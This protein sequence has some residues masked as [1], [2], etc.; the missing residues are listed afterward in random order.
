MMYRGKLLV[1]VAI[2]LEDGS[3]LQTPEHTFDTTSI[4]DES[5]RPR[6]L[7]STKADH[8]DQ[9]GSHRASK[10]HLGICRPNAPMGSVRINHVP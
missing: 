1:F 2:I 5:K 4:Q 8:T 7:T 3:Q 6:R 10:W 9:G